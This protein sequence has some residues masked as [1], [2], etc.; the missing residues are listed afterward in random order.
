MT[1]SGDMGRTLTI[2]TDMVQGT[3]SAIF[4]RHHAEAGKLS[5][6]FLGILDWI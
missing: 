5:D 4:W 1:V 2:G 6:I 3:I